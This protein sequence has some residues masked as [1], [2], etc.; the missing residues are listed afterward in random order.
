MIPRM[1][2]TDVH[3]NDSITR[4][5]K[6]MRVYCD[7]VGQPLCDTRFLFSEHL[8]PSPSS[9]VSCRVLDD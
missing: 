7:R 2:M 6:V 5:G 4:L 3:A 9:V 8:D 1:L